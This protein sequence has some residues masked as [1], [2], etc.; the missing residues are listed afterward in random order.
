MYIASEERKELICIK[1]EKNEVEKMKVEDKIMMKDIRNMN[2]DQN[3][4][5]RLRRLEI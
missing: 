5:I 3:E 2:F 4:Y 1:K